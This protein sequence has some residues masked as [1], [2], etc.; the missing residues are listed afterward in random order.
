MMK[1]SHHSIELSWMNEENKSRNGPSVRWTRFSV[2]KMDPKTHTPLYTWYSTHVVEGLESSTSYSFRLRVSRASREG[3][4][5]PVLSVF[6]TREIFLYQSWFIYCLVRSLVEI[7]VK[8]GTDKIYNSCLL[9]CIFLFMH[10]F[11]FS[12]MQTCFSGHL[13]T[14]KYLR[15]CGS[16]WTPLMRV[17]AISGNAAVTSIILQA[18]ADVYVLDKAGKTPIMV[19]VLNNQKEMVKLL[20]DSGADHHIKNEVTDYDHYYIHNNKNSNRLTSTG[21]FSYGDKK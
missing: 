8:H 21:Q 11:F 19:A 12:L 1:V 4:L 17:S 15:N 20:L 5:S 7:L 2:E 16:L 10:F 13:D 3:S 18:G 6:T 9:T 14:V